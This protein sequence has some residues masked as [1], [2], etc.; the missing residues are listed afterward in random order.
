MLKYVEFCA[1]G[2]GTRA[3][4]G[5]AGWNC[6]LS[7]DNDPDAVFVHNLAFGGAQLSDVTGLSCKDI[8][9]A[10][11]W[12]AGFPCQPFSSSGSRLGFGHRSGNVFEHLHRLIAER[13]PQVVLLENVEGLLINKSGHTLAVI[14][15]DLTRCRYE[16]SWLLVN[17]HW[18]GVPH[19][20][21]RLFLIASQP[22]ALAL[23]SAN[24]FQNDLVGLDPL[25]STPFGILL[26]RFQMDLRLKSHGSLAQVSEQLKP[27][28]GKA[29]QATTGLFGT[30][31]SA[32]GD[33]YTSFKSKK[34]PT[35]KDLPSLGDLVSPNFRNREL[36]R[37]ARYYARGGPTHLC[38]REEPVSH[39]IGTSLG[40]A[41]LYA[42]PSRFV[43]NS[44]D[45]AAFLEFANWHR[46]QDGLLVMRLRPDRAI[47]LFG[48]YTDRIGQALREWD[49]G[50]T[51]KYKV[52]GNMV[53]PI[54]AKEVAEVINAQ[55]V[56]PRPKKTAALPAVHPRP[57]PFVR[58]RALKR[59]AAS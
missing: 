25:P 4:L 1:G 3:G 58:K 52:L 55:L 28:V 42:V 5:A 44:A 49:A 19:S 31:G 13:L 34:F 38:L 41:P 37:S 11:V 21:P 8:P 48:P 2:G 30:C 12:V 47:E 14:L 27:E 59:S 36:L 46:E 56:P 16:V 24:L 9:D 7:V 26:N 54:C 35:R 6:V 50:D 15:A 51:R 18:F 22:G 20:R 57:R 10:D 23:E 43:Q 32:S 17:L 40:G 53:A 39:C 45:K 29:A 33:F